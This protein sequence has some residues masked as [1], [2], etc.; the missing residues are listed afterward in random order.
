MFTFDWEEVKTFEFIMLH[1][2]R[3]HEGDFPVTTTV[4]FISKPNCNILFNS[5]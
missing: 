4:G 2:D 3:L 1:Q 5:I